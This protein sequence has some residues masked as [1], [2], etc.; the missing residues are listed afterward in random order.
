MNSVRRNIRQPLDQEMDPLLT[1]NPIP[2]TA[3]MQS[4]LD[5]MWDRL[6]SEIENTAIEHVS[7]SVSIRPYWVFGKAPWVVAGIVLAAI[8]V[9]KRATASEG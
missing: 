9:R 6:R 4:R 3:E 7:I 2:S 1:R 8:L 5:N